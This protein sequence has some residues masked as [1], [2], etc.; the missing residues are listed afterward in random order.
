MHLQ[1]FLFLSHLFSLG[2]TIDSQLWSP[3]K[4]KDNHLLESVQRSFIRHILG[5][6][7]HSDTDR[8]LLLKLYSLQRRRDRDSLIYIWKILEKIV[9]NLNKPIS[10]YNSNRRGGLCVSSQVGIRHLGSLVYHIFRFRGIRLFNGM[11]KHIRTI[12]GCSVSSFN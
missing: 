2:W 11:P 1:C 10:F 8:L 6:S 7:S 5:I 9:P 12:S 3:Y 4:V